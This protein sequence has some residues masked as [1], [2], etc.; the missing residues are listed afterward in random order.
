MRVAG[1]MKAR[2]ATASPAQRRRAQPT[3][4]AISVEFG[5]GMRFVA[6]RR[7]RNSESVIHPRR[8]TTSS[9]SIAT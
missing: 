3:W 8:L 1:R 5:P 2:P 6:P 9:R 4:I 7:S